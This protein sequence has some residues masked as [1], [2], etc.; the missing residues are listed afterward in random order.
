M[1]GTSLHNPNIK[2]RV[3]NP[4]ART[5]T[6]RRRHTAT[7][8][9]FGSAQMS[10]EQFVTMNRGIDCGQDLP[11]PF[12]MVRFSA[13]AGEGA[14]N[15]HHHPRGLVLQG[16]YERI[17]AE[18][19]HVP[20]EGLRLLRWRWQ[21][22][23]GPR[24]PPAPAPAHPLSP[25]RSLGR[26]LDVF[27]NSEKSGWLTKE[28]ILHGQAAGSKT[29]RRCRNLPLPSRRAQQDM[30]ETVVYP[31]QQLPLLLREPRLAHPQRHHSPGIAG[32]SPCGRSQAAGENGAGV[33]KKRRR[34][35]VRED[36]GSDGGRPGVRGTP[37][38]L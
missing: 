2:D 12:L 32:S 7:D 36:A 16:L 27:V 17:K 10:P 21:R 26:G 33:R 6:P 8:T 14:Q 31:K 29:T 38:L 24:R 1:L 35:A 22:P 30:E 28:G 37:V 18:K 5:S 4:R 15:H 3:S 20:D 34:A 19:F 23:R 13:L 25:L 11:Q 9:V